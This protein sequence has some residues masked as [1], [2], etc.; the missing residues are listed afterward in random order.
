M[1]G[2]VELDTGEPCIIAVSRE[3]RLLSKNI[4]H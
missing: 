3:L 4:K 2:H 1:W